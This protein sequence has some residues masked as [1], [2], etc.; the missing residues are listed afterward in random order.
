VTSESNNRPFMFRGA[1]T[2]RP[3]PLGQR[4][5][6]FHDSALNLPEKPSDKLHARREFGD[7]A[8]IRSHRLP[9]KGRARCFSDLNESVVQASR[10]YFLVFF[11][12][13][14][15]GTKAIEKFYLLLFA[16]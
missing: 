4:S 11:G 6:P 14:D 7:Q 5:F 9:L 1:E 12:A 13:I 3:L 16:R 8:T 2:S 10:L 15:W